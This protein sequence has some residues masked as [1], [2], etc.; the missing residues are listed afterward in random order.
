[1]SKTR[2]LITGASGTIGYHTYQKLITNLDK[3]ILRI[4][5]RGSKKNRKLFKE[6]EEQIEIFWGDILNFEKCKKAV[7]DQNIIIHAAALI[8]PAAYKDQE[9]TKEVNITGTENIL[10]AIQNHSQSVKIIFTSSIAVYGDRLENPFI[11]SG[12]PTNPNDIYGKTKVAAENLIINSG[13]D[14]LIFRISYVATVNSLK[15]DPVMFRMPLD[16]PIEL[17]DPNDVAT[18]IINA[19]SS[20][21][22][23]NKTYLLAGGEKNRILFRNL[24]NKLFSIMGFGKNFLPE[25]AFAKN[26]FNCG[27]C[28]T[29]EIQN[30]LKFQNHHIEDFYEKVDD[31]IGFK[32]Y[33]VPLVKYFIKQYL[34]RKSEYY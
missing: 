27:Y 12:D 17:I 7:A 1:M 9:Y 33:F 20:K 2:I 28:D 10:K 30:K 15:F 3:F 34:L 13:L 4:F 8:P 16:T 5:L 31:W 29:D 22:I 32:K 26:G 18:A 21:D 6:Y 19:I 14:Y 24:I 25:S 11:K 23:W